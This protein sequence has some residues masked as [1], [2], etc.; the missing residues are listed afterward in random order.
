MF[1]IREPLVAARAGSAGRVEAAGEGEP[2]V[3]GVR[4]RCGVEL[5]DKV[6]SSTTL[7][8]QF[9]AGAVDGKDLRGGRVGRGDPRGPSGRVSGSDVE[10]VE[11]SR[12]PEERARA[13]QTFG[14]RQR[15]DFPDIDVKVEVPRLG[16]VAL[17]P[18]VVGFVGP[19][20]VGISAVA[21][22]VDSDGLVWTGVAVEGNLDVVVVI[23]GENWEAGEVECVYGGGAIDYVRGVDRHAVSNGALGAVIGTHL[24]LLSRPAV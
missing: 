3:A 17:P 4:G 9:G 22:A 19:V 15:V 23:R 7:G 1:H 11:R 6:V 20:S 14:H 8:Q 2:R 18:G 24:L 21:I 16:A 12:G 10:G 13:G 5:V